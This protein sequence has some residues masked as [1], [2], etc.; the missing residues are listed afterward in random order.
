MAFSSLLAGGL[1][2]M[3]GNAAADSAER[4]AQVAAENRDIARAD[5]SGWQQGG[6][7]A[8]NQ[9]SKLLGLGS[10][11][12]N[13]KGWSTLDPTNA[14]A[15]QENAFAAFRTDPGYAFRQSEGIKSLDRAAA[16]K[17]MTMSGAQAKKIAGFNQ[18]L[19]S[20]EFGNY[21]SRL[22]GLSGAGG[23]AA[24]NQAQASSAAGGQSVP[25]YI[26][27]GQGRQ[28]AYNAL[29]SGV[30]R[31]DNNAQKWASRIWGGGMMGG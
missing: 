17:G 31:A 6:L 10:L 30:I 1:G 9:I 16:A 24:S 28:S 26:A 19:A 12:T 5:L 8:V 23:N 3:G 11:K 25:A 14:V 15:D 7:G 27:A 18:D 4:G 21:F 13:E 2:F 29:A 22:Q 20:E